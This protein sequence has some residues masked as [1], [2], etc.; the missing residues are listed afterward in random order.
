MARFKTL[1]QC[2][3]ALALLPASAAF[4]AD[5][6]AAQGAAPAAAPAATAS[7][8]GGLETIVVTAQK[9]EQNLQ[10]VPMSV[11][12]LSATTL[13][14]AGV[15]D[16]RSVSNLVPSLSVV[17]T[18]GPLNQSYRI[19]GMGSDANIPTFE[20]DV[21]L[22]VDGVYMPRS[23]LS[24]DDLANV[25]RV[26][27]LEG[28]QS[29]LYGKN[30]TAGVVNVVT[31]AP[32]HQFGGTVEGSIS[33]LDSSISAPVYRFAGYVSGPINDKL[34]LGL[35]VV[36]YNQGDSYKNLVAGA[37]NAN[38]MNRYSVRAVADA[39]LWGGSTLRVALSRSQIY[40]TRTG[41]PDNLYYSFSPPNNALKLDTALGPH[42]GVQIC[43]DNNPNDRIICTSSPWNDSAYNNVGSATLNVPIGTLKLTS[44]TALS[45]YRVQDR[46]GDIAQVILPVLSYNDI[47]K[48]NEF[49]QEVRLASP[50]GETVEWMLGGFYDHSIFSRGDDGQEPTFVV[51]SAGP[52]VPLPA[53]LAAFK[54]GQPGDKGFLNS[55][56]RSDYGAIFTNVAVHLSDKV[57]LSGGVR[58]QTESIHASVGNS[59][60]ISPSTPAPNLGCGPFPVNLLTVS[61]TPTATPKP[62]CTAINSE[63]SNSTSYMTWNASGQYQVTGATMLYASI[64]R[65]AKSFGYNLG[66]GNTLPSQREFQNE[67]VTDYEVGVKSTFL[68]GRARVAASLFYTLEDNYQNAGFVGLQFLVNNA[69]KVTVKGAE[70]NGA[71]ALG[72]GF[73]I[74]AAA[75]YV[76][77][78]YTDYVGGACY[79]GEA[80]NNGAGGCNLSGM[81]L[82]LTPH[83]RTN[84]GLQYRRAVSLGNLYARADW[85]WQ[86]SMLANTNLDPRSLQPAYSLVNLRVGLDMNNGVG[87]ALWANNVFNATYSQADYVSNLFGANDPAYQRFLGRPR[88]FGAT[89][90]KTF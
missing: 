14:Q 17:Q 86:S 58:G 47:Q 84:V 16:M 63:F 4:A 13:Q 15:T 54:V 76:D 36:T 12:A 72:Y 30:A 56:E 49:S 75:N 34:R 7:S 81:G 8:G 50:T 27:V 89:V 65:G 68:D 31:A 2:A 60:S 24:V 5:A 6:P 23:G 25:A 43:P 46:N 83:W 73:T 70:A 20:P 26:E 37:P 41:D 18:V 28:P 3:S 57:T 11:T 85:A 33:D 80:A 44:I 71:F 55:R 35:T 59:Y 29:T 19:R 32:S 66:F 48:G 21:A 87:L 45:N 39:D 9:R 62:P 67:Y 90:K 22:F 61:L 51:G 79:F 74:D 40:N 52:F 88:E 82:P 53:P 64:S 69:K 38:D 1:L 42:F 10:K 78:V 77:A